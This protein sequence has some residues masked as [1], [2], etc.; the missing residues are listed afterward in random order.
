MSEVKDAAIK[1]FGRTISLPP[2]RELAAN[3]SS[4]TAASI[5]DC[6][7][8]SNRSFSSSSPPEEESCRTEREAHG[9][10][11]QVCAIWFLTFWVEFGFE[12][13]SW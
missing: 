13:S 4:A 7:D 3:G 12:F 8:H 2:G 9:D 10:D 5:D 11:I 1:L 6:S